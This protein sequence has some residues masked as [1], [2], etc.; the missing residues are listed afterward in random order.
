MAVVAVA[1]VWHG[2]LKLQYRRGLG[3]LLG[4]SAVSEDCMD[5]VGLMAVTVAY[6]QLAC[7]LNEVYKKK[8]SPYQKGVRAFLKELH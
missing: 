5:V 7:L 4:V 8:S 2:W 6:G 1:K 3:G